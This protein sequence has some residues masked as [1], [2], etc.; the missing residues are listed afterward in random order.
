MKKSYAVTDGVLQWR[1]TLI[2][3]KD[4]IQAADR[5]DYGK[6][7]A[8]VN[9]A[10]SYM[11]GLTKAGTNGAVEV[12]EENPRAQQLLQQAA[13]AMQARQA[14]QAGDALRQAEL[15]NP[16]QRGLWEIY[17][18]Y[19]AASGQT[20][21]ALECFRKEVEMHPDE[22]PAYKTLAQMEL[23]LHHQAEAEAAYRKYQ[24]LEPDDAEASMLLAGLLISDKAYGDALGVL[25]RGIKLAPENVELAT[26]R[27]DTL[28]QAGKKQEGVDA[29]KQ[30]QPKIATNAGALNDVGYNLIDSGADLKLGSE[31]TGKIRRHH[32]KKSLKDTQLSNLD[33][34][35]GL[36]D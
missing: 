31:M 26:M 22:A 24:E 34:G 7:A 27:T 33:F 11:I 28:L 20:Q 16:K 36:A 9:A 10:A 4:K 17:A 32:L 8:A 2:L 19:Y 18:A 30:L 5:E 6:L 21:K 3:H 29:A 12:T 23:Y 35:I 25:D 13:T 1:R 14:S 15:L